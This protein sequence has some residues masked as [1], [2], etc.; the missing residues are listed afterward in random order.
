MVLKP[1][2]SPLYRLVTGESAGTIA[3]LDCADARQ[4]CEISSQGQRACDVPE[5]ESMTKQAGYRLL[6]SIA[7]LVQLVLLFCL[8][9]VGAG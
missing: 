7:I 8:L 4:D 3:G 6:A 2:L 9:V 1:T 5:V